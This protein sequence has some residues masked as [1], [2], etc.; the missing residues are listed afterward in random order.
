MNQS[1]ENYKSCIALQ[2]VDVRLFDL[3]VVR[4][5]LL[6]VLNSRSKQCVVELVPLHQ[7]DD[8]ASLLSYADVRSSSY[9]HNMDTTW[10]VGSP[11]L[12]LYDLQHLGLSRDIK[13]TLINDVM[14]NSGI[15]GLVPIEIIFHLGALEDSLNMRSP[16]RLT[17][18]IRPILSNPFMPSSI[19]APSLSGCVVHDKQGSCPDFRTF[20][21]RETDQGSFVGFDDSGELYNVYFPALTEDFDMV[22][23]FDSGALIQSFP[24]A[25]TRR[26]VIH[27]F[28]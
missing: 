21:L 5:H 7:F 14:F 24:D 19:L 25:Q 2:D 13:C 4:G 23:E 15:R 1:S 18:T 20:R 28:F 27:Q 9:E 3:Q 26:I 11:R 17:R 10:M 12:I 16:S 22:V 8:S 6:H